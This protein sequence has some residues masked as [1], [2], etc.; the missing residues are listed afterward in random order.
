MKYDDVKDLLH[1]DHNGVL[2]WSV[3]RKKAKAGKPFGCSQGSGYIQGQIL[4][5]RMYAHR[6]VWL[7]STG[8]LP[9]A[10]IDHI[11]GNKIDNRFENLRCVSRI[12]NQ[13]NVI[14]VRKDNSIGVKGVV[15]KRGKFAAR[16]TVGYKSVYLGTFDTASEAG[17]AYRKAKEQHHPAWSGL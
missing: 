17:A 2:V 15:K 14:G 10:E 7:L 3:D 4:G 12:D 11:N 5:K 13:Q 1:I 8:L 6:L 9:T 16:I